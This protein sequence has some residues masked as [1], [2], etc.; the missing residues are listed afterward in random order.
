MKKRSFTLFCASLLLAGTSLTSAQVIV[1]LNVGSNSVNTSDNAGV[2]NVNNWNNQTNAEFSATNLTDSSG[3]TSD[4]GIAFGGA[5]G[6]GSIQG[7]DVGTD[8]GSGDWDMFSEGA[9][10][11]ADTGSEVT[12]IT[13]TGL[14]GTSDIYI[15]LG[16][17]SAQANSS[18]LDLTLGSTTYYSGTDGTADFYPGGFGRVT[19]TNAASPDTNT[20]DNSAGTGNLF[21]YVLFENVSGSSA[22]VSL[23]ASAGFQP[24][25]SGV[26]VSTIPEPSTAVL[27][28]GGLGLVMANYRRRRARQ[29]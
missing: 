28:L 24:I 21:N 20:W 29:A 6:F 8:D 17:R 3:A 11:K 1:S 7:S 12:T 26:Q 2:L 23:E 27:L 14:D 16:Q 18:D 22:T 9:R 19:S 13:F 10:V 15:Y 25:I 5:T 4:I